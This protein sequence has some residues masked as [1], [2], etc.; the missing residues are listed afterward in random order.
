MRKFNKMILVLLAFLFIAGF[1]F[2]QN[3]EEGKQFL[4]YERYNSAMNMFSKLYLLIP[5]I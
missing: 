3:K 2:A 5:R 1:A 4:N